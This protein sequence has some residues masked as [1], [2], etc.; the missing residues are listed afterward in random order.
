[1]WYKIAKQGSLWQMISN[2]SEK[3]FDQIFKNSFKN[4]NNEKIFDLETFNQLFQ[5]SNLAEYVTNFLMM[6]DKDLEINNLGTYHR[7]LKSTIKKKFLFFFYNK[8]QELKR[9]IKLNPSLLSNKYKL[10]GILKHEFAHAISRA[11]LNLENDNK[12]IYFENGFIDKRFLGRTI[13]ESTTFAQ[14]WYLVDNIEK[15]Q[16]FK[17]YLEE[18]LRDYQKFLDPNKGPIEYYQQRLIDYSRIIIRYFDEFIKNNSSDKQFLNKIYLISETEKQFY[19]KIANLDFRNVI[20]AAIQNVTKYPRD[21]KSTDLLNFN[22]LPS[23]VRENL[24]L[25]FDEI[26]KLLHNRAKTIRKETDVYYANPE[27]SRAQLIEIL[28]YFSYDNLME[29]YNVSYQQKQNPQEEFL[30]FLKGMFNEIVDWDFKND[31]KYVDVYEIFLDADISSTILH[32]QYDEKFKRQLAKHLTTTYNIIKDQ[33][34]KIENTNTQNTEQI[35]SN[36]DI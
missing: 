11:K 5:K 36:S 1:M 28:D 16:S 3:I 31:Y 30:N 8:T 27:E 23:D 29:F 19:N 15:L 24:N 32:K 26:L 17:S 20:Y 22:E 18:N 10:R 25:N 9:V 2:D 34:Q 14:Y 6:D 21:K 12:E 7:T 4:I 35:D 33:F 13:F